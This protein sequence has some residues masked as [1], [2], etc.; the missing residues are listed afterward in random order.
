MRILT[1]IEKK[2]IVENPFIQTHFIGQYPTAELDTSH[3]TR[4]KGYHTF[5]KTNCTGRFTESLIVVW[6]SN[7]TNPHVFFFL[8]GTM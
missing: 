6:S 3:A 8:G 5:S 1:N 7:P 2:L 4:C